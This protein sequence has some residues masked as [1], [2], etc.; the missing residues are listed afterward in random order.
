MKTGSIP[1]SF[2]CSATSTN[3]PPP[4]LP[5]R[6]SKRMNDSVSIAVTDES[7]CPTLVCKCLCLCGPG[8]FA[9]QHQLR[10]RNLLMAR[11]DKTRRC[12][13]LAVCT[14]RSTPESPARAGYAR[15]TPPK[16]EMPNP[17]CT[18][19]DSAVI[20]AC[21]PPPCRFKHSIGR[22][23]RSAPKQQAASHP[24]RVALEH[25]RNRSSTITARRRSGRERLRIS[26]AGVKSTQSPRTVAENPHPARPRQTF[27]NAL[28]SAPILRFSPRPPASRNVIANG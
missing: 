27:Q 21:A 9:C 6:S 13:M 1:D 3:P 10:A 4:G 15:C 12:Q 8:A 19:P 25:P 28:H 17:A 23:R 26:I 11:P 14:L 22:Q 24:G 16:P 20:H 5:R 7:V 18:R 2:R